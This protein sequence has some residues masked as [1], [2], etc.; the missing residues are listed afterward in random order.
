MET[1]FLIAIFIAVIAFIDGL[2]KG[3]MVAYSI[4]ALIIM[5]ILVWILYRVE[6]QKREAAR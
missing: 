2:I 1:V 6:E 3:S 4:L 5:I